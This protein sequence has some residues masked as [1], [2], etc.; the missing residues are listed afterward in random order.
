MDKTRVMTKIGIVTGAT[1]GLGK[2]FLQLLME[3]DDLQ[4]I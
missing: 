4:E 3:N 2:A 1:G